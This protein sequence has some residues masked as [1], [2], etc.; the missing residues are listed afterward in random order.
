MTDP[1]Q[2]FSSRV[3]NYVKY[4]PSYPAAII[5]L[6]VAECELTPDSIVADVGSGTGL[7]SELFLK[8]GNRVLGIEPNREMREAGEQLLRGYERF[9]SI[10]A[11]AEATTLPAHSVD[12]IT[13]GQAFHWFDQARVSTEFVRI[14]RSQGRI[15]LIWNERRI[16]STPFL[17]AYEQ[18]LRT[19][20]TDYAE[21]DHKLIDSAIPIMRRCWP[22]WR[23]SLRNISGMARSLS[24]TKHAS[25]T[26]R[27]SLEKHTTREKSA[28]T[29]ADVSALKAAGV[30]RLS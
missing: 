27:Q 10:D 17:R 15:V 16:D 29:T 4:R 23:P 26:D 14:L 28:L 18:L 13:A 12:F 11:T 20:S 22:S 1:T 2:R 7:L 25:T 21:V 6:L 5:D 24:S 3:I 19:Y 30:W 9:S 8:A